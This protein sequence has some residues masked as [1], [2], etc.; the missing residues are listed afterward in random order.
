M[1]I[2]NQL[3]YNV[4]RITWFY[5]YLRLCMQHILPRSIQIVQYRLQCLMRTQ[6]IFMLIR[7]KLRYRQQLL[8]F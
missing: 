5:H 6:C 4:E 1:E 7:R 2:R 8:N 3:I